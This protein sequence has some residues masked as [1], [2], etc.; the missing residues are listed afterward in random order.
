MVSF[1]K[2]FIKTFEQELFVEFLLHLLRVRYRRK[3]DFCE[4]VFALLTEALI[5][6][7]ESN[8]PE[9]F[10]SEQL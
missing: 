2:H 8:L 5:L 4:E 6:G 1:L 9:I 7:V 3:V 10:D